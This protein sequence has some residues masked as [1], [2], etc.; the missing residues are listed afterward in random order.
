VLRAGDARQERR[1]ELV[2]D[3]A[4]AAKTAPAGV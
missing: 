1:D 4:D 3:L 2:A